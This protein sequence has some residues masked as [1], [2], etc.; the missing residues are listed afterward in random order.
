MLVFGLEIQ[1]GKKQR[2][3]AFVFTYASKRGDGGG[4]KT[5]ATEI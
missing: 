5:T 3:F 2:I 1:S 4:G